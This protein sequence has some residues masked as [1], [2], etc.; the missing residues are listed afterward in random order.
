MMSLQRRLQHFIE[1]L[2]NELIANRKQVLR[3]LFLLQASSCRLI[4]HVGG[5]RNKVRV[6]QNL[7]RDEVGDKISW[8]NL[9]VSV[10]HDPVYTLSPWTQI[11]GFRVQ[12][13]G[14]RSQDSG[15]R[16]QD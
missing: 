15:L 12:G 7:L 13:S 14:L 11:S 3:F 8:M 5:L 1:E 6:L 10:D 16:L 2:Q 4:T 9:Q